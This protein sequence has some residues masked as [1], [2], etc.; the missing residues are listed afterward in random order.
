MHWGRASGWSCDGGGVGGDLG[1]GG[2]IGSY[3][4]VCAMDGMDNSDCRYAGNGGSYC[5]EFG[6]GENISQYY[7]G[8]ELH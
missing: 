1:L 6:T 2:G 3:W 4:R 5:D 8:L 7:P